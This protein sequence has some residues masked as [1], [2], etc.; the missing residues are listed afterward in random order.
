MNRWQHG[1]SG[2]RMNRILLV[3]LCC[4]TTHVNG[5]SMLTPTP[6][7]ASAGGLVLNW[8][9]RLLQHGVHA[10]H[11]VLLDAGRRHRVVENDNDTDRKTAYPV[12][13]N[14]PEVNHRKTAGHSYGRSHPLFRKQQKWTRDQ[15]GLQR[16]EPV[17]PTMST[18]MVCTIT[19][20]ST[21]FIL[22]AI[23]FVL[24]TLNRQKITE[25]KKEERCWA[26][27]VGSVTFVPMLCVL[28]LAA[29]LQAVQYA[30]GNPELYGLPQW[31]VRLA[32]V[33]C[34]M[35][36]LWS[37]P[38]HNCSEFSGDARKVLGCTC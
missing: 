8:A 32:M 38:I 25:R 34:T 23:F 10:S 12:P 5:I 21:F 17:V 2:L 13:E 30:Q 4:V 20:I 24:Q 37:V 27:V 11:Y 29:R 19:L 6:V 35:A 18:T 14:V 31:W 3:A 16:G 22:T 28:F 1:L 33:I 36:V 9:A 26:N 7:A 15:P